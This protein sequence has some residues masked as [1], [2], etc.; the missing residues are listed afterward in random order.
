MKKVTGI[1]KE[2]KKLYEDENVKFI[3]KPSVEL[4]KAW[5]DDKIAF[6]EELDKI[7]REHDFNLAWGDCNER[8]SYYTHEMTVCNGDRLYDKNIHLGNYDGHGDIEF[9]A[10]ILGAELS[11]KDRNDNEYPY[12][13]SFMYGEW[14]VF[15]LRNDNICQK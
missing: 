3:E 15:Q 12:E 4:V 6:L 14:R 13:Y 9:L 8:Y 10:D 11:Y 2:Y 7:S 5:L 1:L